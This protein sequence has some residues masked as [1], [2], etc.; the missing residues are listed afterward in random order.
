MYVYAASNDQNQC[1]RCSNMFF[2]YLT[3]LN[4]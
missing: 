3:R 1:L 4:K 2:R